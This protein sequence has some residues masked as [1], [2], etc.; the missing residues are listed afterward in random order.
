MTKLT[1][2]DL[3][4]VNPEDKTL[5]ELI[6]YLKKLTHELNNGTLSKVKENKEQC[7]DMAKRAGELNDIFKE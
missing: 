5:E 2:E 3:L 6:E 7:R 4:N 1:L